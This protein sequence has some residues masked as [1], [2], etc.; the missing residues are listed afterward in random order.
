MKGDIYG[1]GVL[2]YEMLTGMPPFYDSKIEILFSK[3]RKGNLRFPTFV[4]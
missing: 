4:E 3:I 2:L 1:I